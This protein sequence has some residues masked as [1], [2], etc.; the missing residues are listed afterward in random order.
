MH[1]VRSLHYLYTYLK[2]NSSSVYILHYIYDEKEIKIKT[3]KM[4]L[5]KIKEKSL[6]EKRVFYFLRFMLKHIR[7]IWV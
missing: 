3:I 1:F 2:N 7:K 6:K 4:I 5:F